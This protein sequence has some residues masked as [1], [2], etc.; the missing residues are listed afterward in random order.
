MKIYIKQALFLT[1]CLI[2]SPTTYACLDG[3]EIK[4]GQVILEEPT[5]NPIIAATN[6]TFAQTYSTPP[7]VFILPGNNNTDPS[8]VRVYD[9]TTTGF[10]V[11]VTEAEAENGITALENFTY[12]AIEPGNYTLGSKQIQAGT[13][14]TNAYYRKSDGGN[15]F[16]TVAFA[17]AFPVP[18]ALPPIVVTEVQTFANDPSYNFGGGNITLP[19]LET[20]GLQANTT[21][22]SFEVALMNGEGTMP[23]TPFVN[24]T[25]AYLAME[26]GM[27]SF[28]DDGGDL[29]EFNVFQTANNINHNCNTNAHELTIPAGEQAQ[30][31]ANL[32]TLSGGDGGWMRQCSIDGTNISLKL[33]E[34][35]ATDPDTNHIV[36]RANIIAFSRDF[37]IDLNPGLPG[38]QIE[39]VSTNVNAQI[40]PITDILSFTDVTFPTPF[41]EI[42]LIFSLPTD[43]GIDEPA[44]LRVKGI[45]V[46]GFSIAQVQPQGTEGAAESMTIDYIA[47]TPKTH[48]LSDNNSSSN[49]KLEAGTIN[50]DAFQGGLFD[51]MDTAWETLNFTNTFD[52]PPALLL[53]IQT[54]NSEPLLNP[55]SPS[56]P[57]LETSIEQGTI[58]TTGA[59]IA[60]D[61]A[62]TDGGTVV[63][64]TIAYLAAESGLNIIF[65]AAGDK[66]ITLNTLLNPA[67]NIRG[68]DNTPN[69]YTSP[70]ASSAFSIAPLV[71]A[72]MAS[73]TGGDG[74]WLRRCSNSNTAVGLIVDED[75]SLDSERSHASAE[76][77]TF[78]A[79]SEAFEWCPPKIEVTKNGVAIRDPINENENAKAIPD[80]LVR[81]TVTLEN[82]AAPNTTDGSLTIT[83]QI[84]DNTSLFIASTAD[85]PET[86]FIFNAGTGV[87]ASGL[88]FTYVDATDTGDSVE[89][90]TDGSDFTYIPDAAAIAAGFDPSITHVRITFTGE[91]TGMVNNLATDIPTASIG[92]AVKV[93]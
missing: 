71:V 79:F 16:T 86:E 87:N 8:T 18:P 45:T 22:S 66:D 59:S 57:W 41:S 93:D 89:F 69:C 26:P 31:I 48:L 84:P 43:E 46:N 81:Y 38:G 27:G 28:T 70:Y 17:P 35:R 39:I 64:E 44:S 60:M 20:F 77:G 10:R 4:V 36:E 1:L 21:N 53:D 65:N 19:T 40:M 2:T 6:I 13:T 5:E 54:I 30:A 78:F 56:E 11:G 50:T 34:D 25:I 88:G 3:L 91:F 82:Q 67:T 76:Q 52:N 92:F 85:Y 83:D 73:S 33:Q 49:I 14:S 15:S 55:S 74:G 51:A 37:F 24:E 90:S 29:V 62:Q 58:T 68:V 9:V 23:A 32:S 80:A 12:F 63:A 47:I 42:P 7:L 75:T 61:R 72:N